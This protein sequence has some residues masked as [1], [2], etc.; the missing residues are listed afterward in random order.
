MQIPLRQWPSSTYHSLENSETGRQTHRHTDRRTGNNAA[1]CIRMEWEASRYL[2]KKV[3]AEKGEDTS[4]NVWSSS[5]DRETRRQGWGQRGRR[6]GSLTGDRSAGWGHLLLPIIR[7]SAGDGRVRWH[8][9]IFHF[10][11]CS[12][13]CLGARHTKRFPRK[14]GKKARRLTLS[15]ILVLCFLIL[16]FSLSP[17]CR[18]F[19]IYFFA[20]LTVSLLPFCLR[21]CVFLH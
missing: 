15:V 8:A 14:W 1:D 2:G 12:T 9:L 16:F 11:F 5:A 20:R 7:S 3:G 21:C 10:H 4:E 6:I 13:C 17:A 19:F 18:H